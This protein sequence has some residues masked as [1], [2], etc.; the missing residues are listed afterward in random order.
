MRLNE[1]LFDAIFSG[2]IP[3][4]D[5][6]EVQESRES[7]YERYKTVVRIIPDGKE[8]IGDTEE[9][10]NFVRSVMLRNHLVHYTPAFRVRGVWPKKLADF[11]RDIL[12]HDPKQHDWSSVLLTV[13]VAEWVV[14]KCEKFVETFHKLLKQYD[15]KN[16]T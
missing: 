14:G 13:E 11:P 9:Y 12:N 6:C 5:V 3:W 8:K 1:Y 7:F 2:S 15:A 4:D 10:K 16:A